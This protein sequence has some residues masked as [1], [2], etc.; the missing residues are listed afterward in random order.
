MYA[1]ARCGKD[2]VGGK[3]GPLG[4]AYDARMSPRDRLLRDGGTS[5]SI[6]RCAVASSVNMYTPEVCAHGV[7]YI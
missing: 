5:G 1:P 3:A 7:S 2:V 6:S 4:T